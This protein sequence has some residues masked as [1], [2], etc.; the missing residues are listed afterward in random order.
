MGKNNY[1]RETIEKVICAVRRTR[2]NHDHTS[3][4]FMSFDQ[5]AVVEST[6]AQDQIKHF[7]S[8]VYVPNL[9]ENIS[10]SCKY[11]VPNVQLAMRPYNKNGN[12]FTNMKS[13]IAKEDKSGVVYKIDCS[14]CPAT[15]IGETIQKLGAR[16]CQHIN[17]SKKQPSSKNLSALAKHAIDNQ[18]GF[19][20]NDVKILVNERNKTKLQIHEVNHIIKFEQNACND[21]SDKKDYSNTYYNLIKM[22]FE[23]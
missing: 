19:N 12:M 1:P 22:G 23:K 5:T 15:Y 2:R 21:K 4:A 10:R 8:M 6:I 18:H 3:Y 20:F 7:S 16:K 17:D 13:K 11:F 9:S 14:D